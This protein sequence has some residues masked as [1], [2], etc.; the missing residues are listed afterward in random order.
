MKSEN[1]T[2]VTTFLD[3][4]EA[5]LAVAQLHHAGIECS[6]RSNEAGGI[7]SPP[8]PIQLLVDSEDAEEARRI[9]EEARS[10]DLPGGASTT[11]ALFLSGQRPAA[12]PFARFGW[13]LLAGILIGI[14]LHLVYENGKRWGEHTYQY[15]NDKDGAPEESEVWKNGALAEWRIDRNGDNRIDYRLH[16]IDGVSSHDELDDNFDGRSD[17]WYTYSPRRLY[18]SGRFDTDFNGTVDA[19]ST[20]KDGILAQIDWQPNGTN[21]IVLRQLF[22]QGVLAE[23]IRDTN[24]DGAFDVSVRFGPFV[25]PIQTNLLA[26]PKPAR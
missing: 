7:S 5:D 15:D 9:L 25:N 13:G 14:L 17:A 10:V 21:V 3:I 22:Q 19:N 26:P 2:V 20:F 4:S 6:I 12:P 18:S 23:E 1:P 24:G 16:Y 11:K 8:Q